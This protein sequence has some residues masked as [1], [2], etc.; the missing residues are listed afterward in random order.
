MATSKQTVRINIENAGYSLVSANSKT[1]YTAATKKDLPGIMNVELTLQLATGKSYGDGVIRSNI[2][3]ITGATI[4][5]G[6]NKIPIEDRAI[7]LGQSY[8]NGILSCKA[9][10]SSPD[11]AF[12]FEVPSDEGTKEQIW[13]YLGK[14]QPFGLS[15]KQI[16][17]NITVSTDEC[18]IE[19]KPRTFDKNILD[20]SDSSNADLT[21]EASVTF[22][23]APTAGA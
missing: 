3:R 17:D 21:P 18:T 16:E 2:S 7:M 9:G 12:Y 20:W 4:K 10:D 23:N 11:V 5:F 8:S 15:A 6:I 19:F 13:L 22:A 14:A 1:S